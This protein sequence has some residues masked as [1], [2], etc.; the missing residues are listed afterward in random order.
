[1][2]TERLTFGIDDEDNISFHKSRYSFAKEYVKDKNVLDI[3]CG[4]G[5][6]TA[7][8]K[9]AGAKRVVGI[10]L[11]KD[12]INHATKIY[13]SEGILFSVGDAQ[14]LKISEI[15]DVIVS[16]ET[17][18]HLAYPEKFL[19]SINKYLKPGGIFIVSTPIRTSGIL[20]DKP[21]NPY[22]VREWNVVE[23]E[24][25]LQNY[26]KDVRIVFQYGLRKNKFPY[27]RT[28]KKAISRLFFRDLYDIAIS[29]PVLKELPPE[30][31]FAIQKDFLVG[32]CR[33]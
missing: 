15:F 9:D 20:Q 6:G 8:L 18:E 33:L 25:L 27:S 4:V 29:H 5:Y 11:S 19:S 26:F 1:M 30:G 16:F 28:I 32:L 3:A 22:H 13:G 23:F 2:I 7:I 17:I 24:H 21:I 10:D 31:C 12:A 14:D